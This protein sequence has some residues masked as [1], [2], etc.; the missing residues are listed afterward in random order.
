MFCPTE[1]LLGA[2]SQPTY[3]FCQCVETAVHPTGV[4][5]LLRR[6]KSVSTVLSL[7][8]ST[9]HTDFN[10]VSRGQTYLKIRLL[11]LASFSTLGC[12]NKQIGATC[13]G[14]I[15]LLCLFHG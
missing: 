1:W 7:P 10:D 3:V 8:L 13:A 14:K 6:C 9:V 11:S 4:L 2:T 12:D 15:V 5:W